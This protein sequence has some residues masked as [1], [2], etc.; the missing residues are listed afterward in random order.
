MRGG[1]PTLWQE[2]L[3]WFDNTLLSR[4]NDKA[5]SKIIS[6]QQRLHEAAVALQQPAEIPNSTREMRPPN[7]FDQV[8]L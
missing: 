6:I 4:L 3:N 8:D 1:N 2:L 5:T 7:S